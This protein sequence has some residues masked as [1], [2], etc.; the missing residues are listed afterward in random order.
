MTNE[1]DVK[2]AVASLVFASGLA[3]AAVYGC[4][5][6]SLNSM[7]QCSR[8]NPGIEASFDDYNNLRTIRTDAIYELIDKNN[9]N[10]ERRDFYRA[11]V[12]VESTDNPSAVSKAGARGLMQIMPETWKD[13][14]E[15]PYDRAFDAEENVK[16]GVKYLGQIENYLSTRIVGWEVFSES[17]RLELI[18][19]A[20]NGGMGRLV[21][22]K[23]MIS[24]MP[25]ETR[26]YVRKVMSELERLEAGQ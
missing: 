10:I 23:G 15:S 1:S 13:L 9:T 4:V 26:D 17:K 19:A 21:R 14:T 5:K 12:R 22:E 11:V 20:Y 7:M 18:A 24:K 2:S 6:N 16:A 8:E 3:V 25:E